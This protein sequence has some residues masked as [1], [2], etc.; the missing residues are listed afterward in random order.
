VERLE[1]INQE[2]LAKGA[3]YGKGETQ[4]QK[5][6]SAESR[7]S[8]TPVLPQYTSKAVLQETQDLENL[9]CDQSPPIRELSRDVRHVAET[10]VPT[11][12]SPNLKLNAPNAFSHGFPMAFGT[13]AKSSR[14]STVKHPSSS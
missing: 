13:R 8:K 11:T 4:K 14:R 5:D 3:L 9:H 7:K 12:L 1:D 2:I 10:A 6:A